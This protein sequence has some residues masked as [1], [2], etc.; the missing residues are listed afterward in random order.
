MRRHSSPPLFCSMP[1]LLL[2]SLPPFPLQWQRQESCTAVGSPAA[3]G[4]FSLCV[5]RH[6]A[7]VVRL[8]PARPAVFATSGFQ[9]HLGFQ[10]AS[11][12]GIDAG[13]ANEHDALNIVP[14]S[15]RERGLFWLSPNH[16]P[17]CMP[18]D[19]DHA[20]RV[21][22]RKPARS[23]TKAKN[24]CS[25]SDSSHW[26]CGFRASDQHGIPANPE[27]PSY[28]GPQVMMAKHSQHIPGP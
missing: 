25:N 3:R 9:P 5:F 22:S 26:S 13:A 6:Y 7:V 14:A 11:I 12:S 19:S 4:F 23:Y 28:P 24:R 20:V 2:H 16:G 21:S 18:Q 8:D 27:A 10:V 1:S 15:S 17:F